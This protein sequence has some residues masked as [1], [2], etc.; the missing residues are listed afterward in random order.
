MLPDEELPPET[1]LR[2]YA[3]PPVETPAP[4]LPPLYELTPDLPLTPMPLE[5]V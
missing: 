1:P 2:V 5:P 3:E 4:L